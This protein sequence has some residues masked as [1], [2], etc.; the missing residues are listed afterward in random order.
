[1]V[2]RILE[3]GALVDVSHASD[4][5]ADAVIQIAKNTGR[6]IVASHSNARRLLD[7]R[8]NLSDELI[9]GIA[10]TGGMIGINFHSAFLA[11]GRRATVSDVVR[12]IM[13]VVKRVGAEHVAIGS[14]F[15]GDILPPVEL[16]TLGDVQ[17]LV[18]AL[19]QAGLTDAQVRGI[20]G[21]NALRV[22]TVPVAGR[23]P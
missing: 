3:L 1:L 13:Y 10:A 8:R 11:Q 2:F 17:H 7:H 20:L 16:A 9:D 6:P 5:C 19:R 4:R 12:H 14:D 18:P 23:K 21:E 22:L 15:E